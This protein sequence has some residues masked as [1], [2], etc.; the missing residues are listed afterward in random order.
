LHRVERDS[1]STRTGH[2][3]FTI[4]DLLKPAQV[5]CKIGAT[6]LTK[7]RSVRPSFWS[8]AIGDHHLT[9]KYGFRELPIKHNVTLYHSQEK[10]MSS[11]QPAPVCFLN[12][13][14]TMELKT[15]AFPSEN[16]QQK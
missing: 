13:P 12:D 1:L 11:A 14:V 15:P 6:K 8:K 7:R 10:I 16:Q 9:A 4:S 5:P 2:I 3:P